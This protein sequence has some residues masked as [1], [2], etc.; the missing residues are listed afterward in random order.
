MVRK[1]NYR[2]SQ[3]LNL[4]PIGFL[5]TANLIMYLAT[6]IK[7]SLFIGLFGLAGYR[8]M[9]QPWTIMTNM[10]IH[11]P[12]PTIGHILA[13]MMTLYFFGGSLIRLVGEKKFFIVYFL[14][15][16]LGNIFYL[17]LG[18]PFSVAIGA[19]GAVFA[20]GGAMTVLRPKMTVFIIPIPVPIR[21]WVAILGG[22]V[23]ISF[24]PGVAWQ[25]HLGGLLFG[26]GAGYIFRRKP[27]ILY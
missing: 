23:I 24:F 21:L 4:G 9:A 11:S 15:G 26:L 1:V 18:N 5:I 13:N 27:K 3:G 17:L 7:P 19:S 8:F 10:F 20:I 6:S 16:L 2:G 12:F 25:A 14:G 22:F